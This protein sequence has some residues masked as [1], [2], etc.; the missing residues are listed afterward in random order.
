MT[1]LSDAQLAAGNACPPE[2]KG[3]LEEL[4][5]LLAS[6]FPGAR[7]TRVDAE[8]PT[9]FRVTVA[10]QHPIWDILDANSPWTGDTEVRTGLLIYVAPAAA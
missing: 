2:L 4:R 6:Q 7:I 9:E 10:S 8:R 3:L 5:K 1:Q